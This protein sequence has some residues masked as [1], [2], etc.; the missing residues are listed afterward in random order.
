MKAY[1]DSSVLLRL[2]L[3]EN[4]P[5]AEWH[6]LTDACT[7]A[8]TPVECW[9]TLDRLTLLNPRDEARHS[10]Y[11]AHLQELLAALDTIDVTRG[12]LLRASQPLPVP[13][14][15]LDAV[16]LASAL[17]WLEDHQETWVFATHDGA[18]GRAGARMGLTVIG[19]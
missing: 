18:L 7:S 11:R 5:L 16:H 17:T 10:A 14:K 15:T 2:V 1:I 12:I 13:V 19:V 9:R 8:V 3:R 4:G 6:E